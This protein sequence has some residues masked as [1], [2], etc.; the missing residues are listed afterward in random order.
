[1]KE[2]LEPWLGKEIGCNISRPFH[3]DPVIVRDVCDTYFTVE[4][5]S[6]GN[7]HYLNYTAIIQ[8]VGNDSGVKTGGLFEHKQVYPLVVNIRHVVQYVPA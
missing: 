5:E 2:V 1:M 3:I 7:T 4:D 8:V 6:A